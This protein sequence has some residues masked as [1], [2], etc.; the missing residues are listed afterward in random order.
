MP[1]LTAKYY[2]LGT[3]PDSDFEKSNLSVLCP[4]CHSF[5]HAA[6]R[7]KGDLRL[8]IVGSYLASIDANDKV[9]E[10]FVSIINQKPKASHNI[11]TQVGGVK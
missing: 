10:S 9:L 2:N 1:R 6:Q 3:M 8:N 5:I 4:N 7:A 11:F